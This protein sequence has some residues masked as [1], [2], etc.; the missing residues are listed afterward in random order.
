M[1]NQRV[2]NTEMNDL[3][4]IF[5][6]FEHSIGYQEKHGYPAWKNY[7]KNAIIRDI[8]NK[9]QYKIVVGTQ[10]VIVFS[11]CYSDR[12]IW[13]NLDQ[14]DSLYLHGIV[15]NPLFKG[16]KLFGKIVDWAI[17]H[18]KQSALHT[19]WMDT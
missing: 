4:V 7:D 19:I 6:L 2:T 9:N 14:G 1:D 18:A 5:S 13:R 15:V 11:V 8:E 3:E 10:I 12:V 17:E 16:Q